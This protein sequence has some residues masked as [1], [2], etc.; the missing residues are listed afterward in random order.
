MARYKVTLEY[1][2]SRYAG[3][4]IQK[5]DPTIQGELIQAAVKVFDTDVLEIYGSGRTDAGVHARGQVA[6]LDVPSAKPVPPNKIKDQINALL[7]HDINI[8]SIVPV[9]SGFHARHDA[10]ERSYRYQITMRRDA[11]G[12]KYN[13]WVRESL[14][15]SAMRSAA[16]ILVGFHDFRAF[17][18][19]DKTAK[20][21][22][23]HLTRLDLREDGE[24]LYVYISAS[25]FLWKMVR[26][27]VG[28]LV[29]V[30]QGQLTPDAVAGFLANPDDPE[31]ARFTAPAAGLFLE[32][33]DY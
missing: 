15:L 9:E 18:A 33:V 10:R 14:N 17:G 30:G 31:P 8:L 5:K 25:H 23:V 13:W 1:D 7:P 26:R 27:I 20:S 19:K 24:H 21:T 29:A 11:F 3:W 6:H 2:G 28:V 32:K 22:T 12:K 4:Q 16:E